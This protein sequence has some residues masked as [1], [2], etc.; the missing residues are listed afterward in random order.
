MMHVHD[1]NPIRKMPAGVIPTHSIGSTTNG[2]AGNPAVHTNT[3][4]AKYNALN[5]SAR[6]TISN[7]ATNNPATP[8]FSYPSAFPP[9]QGNLT[10]LDEK[11]IFTYTN[12]Y[13]F[14]CLK[15]VNCYFYQFSGANGSMGPNVSANTNSSSSLY[16]VLKYEKL[17]KH[18]LKSDYRINDIITW[19]A[20]KE[21]CLFQLQVED[22]NETFDPNVGFNQLR[23]AMSNI[24][25]ENNLSLKLMSATTFDAS[26]IFGST[27]S[28][29]NSAQIQIQKKSTNV[30]YLSFLKAVHRFIL[31]KMAKSHTLFEAS[32][33]SL[34]IEIFPYSGQLITS[35]M[36]QKS[37]HNV[38]NLTDPQGGS[39][40]RK[41]LKKLVPYSI[42]KLSP[43][44]NQ[45]NELI[46]NITSLKKIFFRLTDYI[47]ITCN[48]SIEELDRKSKFAL[49]IAPSGIRCLIAGESYL[50]S[51]TE[52]PPENYEKLFTVLKKFND[53]DLVSHPSLINAKRLWIKIHPCGFSSSTSAPNIANYLDKTFNTG[54]KY[55]YWP[56]EL[57]F[58]QLASDYTPGL[59]M[60]DT[61]DSE[62]LSVEDPYQIVEDF[63]DIMDEIRLSE[64][65]EDEPQAHDQS[66]MN[67]EMENQS[68]FKFPDGFEF[69]PGIEEMNHQLKP[70]A[71]SELDGLTEI[72]KSNKELDNIFN[73]SGENLELPTFDKQSDILFQK[74]LNKVFEQDD[75][76]GDMHKDGFEHNDDKKLE[77]NLEDDWDDLFG[78]SMDENPN[79][80]KD[81]EIDDQDNSNAV[82]GFSDVAT[83]KRHHVTGASSVDIDESMDDA[84]DSAMENL[85]NE[86]NTENNEGIGNSN[87]PVEKSNEFL[88]P[89]DNIK[90]SS[91]TPVETL[92]TNTAEPKSVFST[93]PFYHDP[94]APSP[95]T[96]QIFAPEVSP[97]GSEPS[98][99]TTKENL[100]TN[101]PSLTPKDY[102][103]SI[104]SPL[105]FNPLIQKDIDSKYSNGGK[106]FVRNSSVTGNGVQSDA[107]VDELKSSEVGDAETYGNDNEKKQRLSMTLTAPNFFMGDINKGSEGLGIIEAAL[108]DSDEDEGADVEGN[109]NETAQHDTGG[110][111]E[112]TTLNMTGNSRSNG[113]TRPKENTQDSSFM[114]LVENNKVSSLLYD[115]ADS[116]NSDNIG[117]AFDESGEFRGDGI[118]DLIG[119]NK[120][121]DETAVPGK[122]DLTSVYTGVTDNNDKT[123]A[124]SSK[125]LSHIKRAKMASPRLS[126]Q[127]MGNEGNALK[128]RRLES[129]FDN[130]NYNGDDDVLEL[131]FDDD[132]SNHAEINLDGNA[133]GEE[134]DSN[135]QMR[136]PP[137][138]QHG[139]LQSGGSKGDKE[140]FVDENIDVL[141]MP[142]TANQHEDQEELEDIDI[143]NSWFF[144]LRLVAPI[145]IPFNFLERPTL[146]IEKE[147]IN[148]LLPILQEL[149]LYSQKDMDNQILDMLVQNRECP[150]VLDA[151]VEYL[152]YKIFP[153]LCKMNLFEL[154]DSSVDSLHS[155]PFGCLFSSSTAKPT[156]KFEP[157][158]GRDL[159][160]KFYEENSYSY[161]PMGCVPQFQSSDVPKRVDIDDRLN[162]EFR[163]LSVSASI[164]QNNLFRIN[165]T[166]LNMRRSNQDIVVNK[167]ALSFWKMLELQPSYGEK[168]FSVLFVTPKANSQLKFAASSFLDDIIQ[169]YC[170]CRLGNIKRLNE[171]GLLEVSC[172]E[173][174]QESYWSAAKNMLLSIVGETQNS[175]MNDE[176]NKVLLLMVDPFQ[177]L[178]SVISMADMA[179]AFET[180]LSEKHIVDNADNK[181]KKKRK[182]RTTTKLSASV[183]FKAFAL[184]KFFT[185]SDGQ[186]VVFTCQKLVDQAFELYNL[187]PGALRLKDRDNMFKIEREIQEEVNFAVS[188]N[189]PSKSV[190]DDEVFLHLCY[191]RSV[192]K[193]WC[194]A[195]WVDQS[196]KLNFTKSWCICEGVLGSESF[197]QIADEMMSIT[198]DYVKS[199]SSKTYVILTRLS[200]IIPDDEL[201]EWKRLSMKNNDVLLV[202][203]TAELESSTMI[204]S[205]NPGPSFTFK[206]KEEPKDVAYTVASTNSQSQTPAN[207]IGA[208]SN[209]PTTHHVGSSKFESPDV[210]MYTPSY[211]AG[212][213][214]LD[215]GVSHAPVPIQ[216][217]QPLYEE[218]EHAHS[219]PQ[220]PIL[221]DIAD[222]CYGLILQ[223]PQPLANQPRIPLK[224]AFL[225][226]TGEGIT[227]N[228]VLELNLLSCQPGVSTTDFVKKLLIQYCHLSSMAFY[229]GMSRINRKSGNVEFDDV[230]EDDEEDD[231]NFD[232]RGMLPYNN[233]NGNYV[234]STSGC[235]P[236][237]RKDRLRERQLIHQQYVQ[238]HRLQ[239]RKK[240]QAQREQDAESEEADGNGGTDV[241]PIHMLSVRKMLD[242]VANIRVE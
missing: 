27:G 70:L 102:K 14:C 120:I 220:N 116:T 3:G 197:E 74:E 223:V 124:G 207:M 38:P 232:D 151:D 24:I 211:D 235:H 183:F 218:G 33:Q 135:Y 28:G 101:T 236:L 137:E 157:S 40:K 31:Q 15:N 200:N 213:S 110:V 62:K 127:L 208:T 196:G 52:E 163:K 59:D 72:M 143:P 194:V 129:I 122:Q 89:C 96:F 48:S 205:N 133:V 18:K 60:D 229:F 149:V 158:K 79:D 204:M 189:A 238:L 192:D 138:H 64:Q 109:T 152:L 161:S 162:D 87:S 83:R 103:R 132:D 84:V 125:G 42:M 94:G 155:K 34:S 201:A 41:I 147:K 136:S 99:P 9:S 219:S 123:S 193:R 58:I 56:L 209:P 184:E 88:G 2:P 142:A 11:S 227:K 71:E 43:S 170:S 121:G 215:A 32:N 118:E 144:V 100:S 233:T 55:I 176:Q 153:D 241:A 51:I 119:G 178:N 222:E 186:K 231:L 139:E 156:T 97:K 67:N 81:A 92:G 22:P 169:T 47:T 63:V 166:V 30:I 61:L 154:L 54:K 21:L 80:A 159:E 160:I 130:I 217:L 225:V 171:T 180:A 13:K 234:G 57:C 75:T 179:H 145:Q 214:P 187:C 68:E 19:I 181:K 188:R 221:V 95:I 141:N 108:S 131:E 29:T 203:M 26:K 69:N 210:M 90:T 237:D 167:T 7:S 242:F 140:P 150:S 182:S 12:Y 199:L 134:P 85:E 172:Q 91:M 228:R 20:K 126:M 240:R 226:N 164:S 8:S 111:S 117:L 77:T 112:L 195:S 104:F 115:L 105:N 86:L 93:S 230:I 174:G 175:F 45:K 53:I 148:A 191:E 49:Y 113:L 82:F 46:V 25:S 65:K 107:S 98:A 10:G 50:D 177:D 66:H 5:T 36:I 17:I 198:I 239:Q 1:F 146:K 114:D 224:T 37:V 73:E 168:S 6:F 202:V 4:N 173:G 44:L 106:F 76:T 216:T 206:R 185:N 23:D 78:E 35:S 128:R 190:V 39:K 212:L 16:E 165:S